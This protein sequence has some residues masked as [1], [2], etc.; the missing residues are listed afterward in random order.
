VLKAREGLVEAIC[1][2]APRQGAPFAA[3]PVLAVAVLNLVASVVNGV[4]AVCTGLVPVAWVA[5]GL[6]AGGACLAGVGAL[7]CRRWRG[8]LAAA[9]SAVSARCDAILVSYPEA[10]SALSRGLPAGPVARAWELVRA[11]ER[12]SG[13]A[14]PLRVCCPGSPH[15]LGPLRAY[16]VWVDGE[17][18]GTTALRDGFDHRLVTSVGRH[19]VLVLYRFGVGPTPQ[20]ALGRTPLSFEFAIGAAGVREVELRPDASTWGLSV[21]RVS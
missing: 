11:L 8:K 1:A 7:V 5:F 12:L 3:I 10:L 18:V 19:Q 20:H 2:V 13:E 6:G 17:L 15:W 4:V 21:V 14:R 16:D 9:L